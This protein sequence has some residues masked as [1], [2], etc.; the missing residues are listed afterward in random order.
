MSASLRLRAAMAE[1]LVRGVGS[2]RYECPAQR[3]LVRR[4]TAA[5]A[6][7]LLD[8][9]LSNLDEEPV[10]TGLYRLAADLDALLGQAVAK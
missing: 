7:T 4:E 10:S 8:L 2:T 6:R 1:E 5:A 9:A 3:A